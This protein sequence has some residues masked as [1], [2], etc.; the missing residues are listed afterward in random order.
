MQ[1]SWMIRAA[2]LMLLLVASFDGAEHVASQETELLTGDGV[3]LDLIDRATGDRVASITSPEEGLWSIGTGW[4]DDWAESWSHG[5]PTSRRRVGDWNVL[6]G[7]VVT[8][9]GEWHITDSLRHVGDGIVEA[10]RRWRYDGSIPSGPVVLSIRFQ[11]GRDSGSPPLRP[12]L[13][14]INYFGNPSGTRI[15]SARVPTWSRKTRR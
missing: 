6:S 12:F 13:P 4:T 15:D 3:T 9:D 14:G 7:K 10:K 1:G 5:S 11:V 2:S 8:G